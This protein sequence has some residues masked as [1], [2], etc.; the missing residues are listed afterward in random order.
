MI[1][2]F[3]S[4]QHMQHISNTNNMPL[5]YIIHHIFHIETNKKFTNTYKKKK[6]ESSNHPNKKATL[7][8][9]SFLETLPT[10]KCHLG[11]NGFCFTGGFQRPLIL[12]DPPNLVN[13]YPSQSS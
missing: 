7:R 6:E 11:D 5:P 12:K 1:N 13:I 10:K 3:P 9:L 2:G 8:G 4:F